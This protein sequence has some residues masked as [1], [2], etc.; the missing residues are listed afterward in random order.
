MSMCPMLSGK[1]LQVHGPQLGPIALQGKHGVDEQEVPSLKEALRELQHRQRT[2]QSPEAGQASQ[3]GSEGSG[4][5]SGRAAA[6]AQ[7]ARVLIG[8]VMS[9]A[10]RGLLGRGACGVC[11]GVSLAALRAQ[12]TPGKE[13]GGVLVAYRS[14]CPSVLRLAEARIVL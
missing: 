9:E 12:Q 5:A 2:K 14:P 1:M 4:S 10:P 13:Q 7:Q 6:G 3:A 8:Y 11:L